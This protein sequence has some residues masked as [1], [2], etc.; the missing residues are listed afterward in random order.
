MSVFE[1]LGGPREAAHCAAAEHW[2]ER[3]LADLNTIALECIPAPGARPLSRLAGLPDDAFDHDGQLTKREVRAATLARL[4]PSPGQTL[5]DV[6]A[7]CGSIAIEW[8][9]AAPDGAAVA[10]ERNPARAAMIAR[11]AAMLGVP[12]L[13]V[14]VG[15]A[16]EALAG[17][18]EPDAVFVGGGVAESGILPAAW[19]ALR[20]GGRFVANVVSSEGERTVLEWQARHGGELCRIAV[21]RCEKVREHHLWRPLMT[22]TQLAATKS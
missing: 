3:Q 5:W 13:R 18:A 2:G 11:N 16:P 21:S 9:R 12:S 22:V 19:G 8:L 15:A 14:V 4:A 1:H 17:L 20:P 10:I 6:G 7:G